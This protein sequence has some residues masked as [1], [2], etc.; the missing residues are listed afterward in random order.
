MSAEELPNT[1]KRPPK[2]TKQYTSLE[3]EELLALR[4]II[5]REDVASKTMNQDD[6]DKLFG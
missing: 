2:V 6:V 1:S 5:R 4:K 3:I